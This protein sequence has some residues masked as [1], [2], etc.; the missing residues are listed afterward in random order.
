MAREKGAQTRLIRLGSILRIFMEREKVLSSGLSK[1]FNTTPRTIQRDLLLLKEAGF[2]LHEIVKGSYRMD[3]DLVKNLEIFDDAELAL[4]VALKNMVG[5]LGHPFQKAANSVLDRLHEC[6]VAMP[7]FVKIDDAVPIDSLLLNRIVK[8]VNEKRQ[9]SF[10]YDSGKG[11]HPVVLEPYRVAY[12]TGFWYLIGKEPVSGIVKR[13]AMDKIGNFRLTKTVF[14]AVPE[15]FDALLE[16]SFNIWF[17]GENN[18]EITVIVDAE[19]S[20]YFRRR[21]MLP[22]QEIKEERPDGSVVV[23]TRVGQYESILGVIKS[24]IPHITVVAPDEFRKILL[25]EVREWIRRQEDP[26]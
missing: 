12:F 15:N 18:L 11:V 26:V 17:A 5:Q 1:E 16:S 14:K 23:T 8:A 22:D 21:K 25:N 13:Y 10:K 7:V 24:W 19:C 6:V 3:K 20:N 9:V 2:P 4:I